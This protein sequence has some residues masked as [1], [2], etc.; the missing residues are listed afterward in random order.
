MIGTSDGKQYESPFHLEIGQD[1]LYLG[2]GAAD[3]PD[4]P[5]FKQP[6]VSKTERQKSFIEDSRDFEETKQRVLDRGDI[7]PHPGFQLQPD[8]ERALNPEMPYKRM[9]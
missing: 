8:T 7:N 6:D 4:F 1:V 2:A 5:A 3:A 9:L